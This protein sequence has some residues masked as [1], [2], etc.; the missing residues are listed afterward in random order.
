MTGRGKLS[1]S[2]VEHIERLAEEIPIFLDVLED[3][4]QVGR[5]LPCL[6]GTTLLGRRIGLGF[7]C[8]GLKIAWTLGLWDSLPEARQQAW[9]EHIRSFQ[10]DGRYKNNLA[11]ENA[12]VDRPEIDWLVRQMP[13][14]ARLHYL[15]HKTANL[16]YHQLILHAETKQAIATLAQVGVKGR[17]A[18][19]GFPQSSEDLMTHFEG[20]D[21][22]QP[23]GAGAHTA[24]IAVFLA[25]DAP[26]FLPTATVVSLRATYESFLASVV[27]QATGTYFRGLMPAYGQLVN[28]A[29]K[30]LT[31]LDWLGLPIHYPEA[32]IDTTLSGQPDHES[33]HLVDAVYLLYRASLQT[34]HRYREV[35]I[36]T[37]EVLNR[38]L[39]HHY[40]GQGF[41]YF[42]DHSQTHYY[43]IPIAL[44]MS[45]ADIHGTCLLTWATAM[46][47]TLLDAPDF[48]WRVIRP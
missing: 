43:T 31:G 3:P 34:R 47:L 42:L 48:G 37:T 10:I 46:S 28:G 6:Q 36:W 26:R 16:V 12:F 45:E 41:S 29:M 27:D 38:I 33:C 23:W 21:W 15:F 39:A 30:V 20:F 13:W 14:R 24:T 35:Q 22:S 8:F 44:G 18:Y 32:L 25:T 2:Q 17:Y 11:S 1:S 40:P 9:L 7:S 19:R 4:Q 5:F